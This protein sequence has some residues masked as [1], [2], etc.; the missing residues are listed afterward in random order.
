MKPQVNMPKNYQKLKEFALSNKQLLGSGGFFG[1]QGKDSGNFKYFA[2]FVAWKTGAMRQA[3]APEHI[4]LTNFLIYLR[5]DNVQISDDQYEEISSKLEHFKSTSIINDDVK[6]PDKHTF[7]N[8]AII[9]SDLGVIENKNP[10]AEYE[11][12][13]GFALGGSPVSSSRSGAKHVGSPKPGGVVTN[14]PDA[15]QENISTTSSAKPPATPVAGITPA[16]LASA[17]P[18]TTVPSEDAPAVEDKERQKG[19]ID[20][21]HEVKVEREPDSSVLPS[22]HEEAAREP[23][24]G[25]EKDEQVEGPSGNAARDAADAKPKKSV[26]DPLLDDSHQTEDGLDVDGIAHPAETRL[27]RGE[28]GKIKETGEVEIETDSRNVNGPRNRTNQP[29]I[30]G[31]LEIPTTSNDQNQLSPRQQEANR[32]TGRKIQFNP[33]TIPTRTK[34]KINRTQ[35]TRGDANAQ[36]ETDE[37][38]EIG[39][40]TLARKPEEQKQTVAQ[41]SNSGPV[42]RMKRGIVWGSAGSIAGAGMLTGSAGASAEAAMLYAPQIAESVITIIQTLLI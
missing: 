23:A 27:G 36:P 38:P 34:K 7:S 24:N 17:N 3:M 9:L 12:A 30:A 25:N 14:I 28:E 16:P 22:Q 21:N 31:T 39:P 41:S 13:L 42:N 1:G 5:S 32:L 4:N 33:G 8:L 19:E 29:I 18:N 37:Q 20:L 35:D 40:Q 11:K 6:S 26:T 10:V 15:T 2:D